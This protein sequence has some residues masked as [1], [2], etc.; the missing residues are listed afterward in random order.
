MVL[1]HVDTA[2]IP[3]WPGWTTMIGFEVCCCRIWNVLFSVQST[4]NPGASSVSEPL[5]LK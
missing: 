5:D 1:P 4:A 3:P 2:Q